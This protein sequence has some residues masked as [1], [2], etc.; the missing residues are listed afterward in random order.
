[1]CSVLRI[2]EGCVDVGSIP[3]AH[4]ACGKELLETVVEF[5]RNEVASQNKMEAFTALPKIPGSR[6]KPNDG[7]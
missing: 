7:S 2:P 5:V 3:A 6:P 1:M 4:G